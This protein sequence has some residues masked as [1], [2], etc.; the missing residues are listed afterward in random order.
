MVCLHLHCGRKGHR[1]SSKLTAPLFEFYS[2]S[3]VLP[4]YWN[5]TFQLEIYVCHSSLHL[6]G[7]YFFSSHMSFLITTNS[8][9]H[10]SKN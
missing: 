9:P 5:M 2:H 1:D 3:L 4:N 7:Q 10:P 6:Y 8:S